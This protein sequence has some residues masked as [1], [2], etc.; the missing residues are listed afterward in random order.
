MRAGVL[1]AAL[2][3][4]ACGLALAVKNAEVWHLGR[5]P[6]VSTPLAC[7]WPCCILVSL[8]RGLTP[9]AGRHGGGARGASSCRRGTTAAAAAAAAAVVTA[10]AAC[11]A[12][13]AAV[14]F[15]LSSEYVCSSGGCLCPGKRVWSQTAEVS[16]KNP[17][18]LGVHLRFG[19]QA[20]D[21]ILTP[22]LHPAP[23]SRSRPVSAQARARLPGRACPLQ[24]SAG[25]VLLTCM[26]RLSNDG[27]P[28][29]TSMTCG[30]SEVNK[31]S[32]NVKTSSLMRRTRTKTGA[33][34]ASAGVHARVC[35]TRA[36]WPALRVRGTMG[37]LPIAK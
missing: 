13:S 3:L 19:P 36:W 22:P 5:A 17:L 26:R 1:L 33:S 32:T 27:I 15:K 12:C 20:P 23:M 10:A 8:G 18:R 31:A 34:E 4:A 24:P 30:G 37:D 28:H 7:P 11:C 14:C 25:I 6:C 9:G 16:P 29:R 35:P 2:L 21:R